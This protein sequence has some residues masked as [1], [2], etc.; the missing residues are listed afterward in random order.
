VQPW[1]ASRGLRRG[2]HIVRRAKGSLGIKGALI[3]VQDCQRRDRASSN[4]SGLFPRCLPFHGTY[5]VDDP[6]VRVAPLVSMRG[7]VKEFPGIRANDRID[8]ELTPGEI[9]AL[10]GEN[11]AGKTTLMNVL[12]G[13]YRPDAGTVEIGGERVELRSPRDAIGRGVGMVHQHFRL[14][15]RFTVAEN[16]TLGWHTPRALIGRRA[17]ERDVARLAAVYGMQVEAGRLVWQLSVGEQQRVEILK[18]LYRGARVLIL[19]EPTAVLTPQEA[20]ALFESI[21][22][23]A[24]EGRGIVLITHKLAE[25]EA[26]ADRVTV[27]RRGIRVA[28][29]P[30]RETTHGELARLMIGR[31]LARAAAPAAREPGPDLLRLESLEVDDD[32]GLRAVRGAD[33]VV[34]EGEIVGLA[35]VAGNGQRELAEAIVGLRP[36]GAGRILLRGE[37][38]SRRS[39][40]RRI[41]A[42]IGYM[43]EDRL[44]DGVAP[45]LSVTE[46]LVAKSYRRPPVGRALLVDYRAAGAY[47]AELAERFDVRG[48]LASSTATLSGGNV[49]KLVLAREI[50]AGASLLVAA[51][52]TRGLDL[53]AAETTRRLLLELRAGGA[54]VLLITEDLDELVEISD[55]IAV[56]YE[57]RITGVLGAGEADEERLGLLMAGRVA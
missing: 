37:D 21:R 3:R 42:G 18:T 48:S 14:V 20:E 38:V 17:L 30:R 9:H 26:V 28:T 43:P 6:P 36:V 15:G 27:L 35:G 31:D 34:R 11:G 13:L 41:D 51:Q 40:Q 46:N 44:R 2:R 22:N 32:R 54:G 4:E 12:S 53:G 52:P 23:M 39:I 57:G 25:V 5:I 55:R 16:V 47:A 49:Q 24:A 56:V 7:I 19:D 10:L 33:L 1:F 45:A 29:L 8:F 50:S